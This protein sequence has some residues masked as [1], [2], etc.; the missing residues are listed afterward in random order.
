MNF[1]YQCQDD[2]TGWLPNYGSNDGALFFKLNDC[3]YRDYHPQLD[4]LHYL[5]TSEHLYDRQYEDREWYLCE[6]KAN[7][8]MYP[9]IKKQFGCISFDKGG[10]YCIREKD[11]FLL[12][13]V[14]DIRTDLRM[15]IICIWIFGI[16]EKII[17]LMGGVINTIQQRS[18]FD[19][20]WVRNLIIQ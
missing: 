1:L 18:Y 9:P 13:D 4:A 16:R 12:S 20:L 15:R 10:Y 19:I 2:L 7:R 14:E 3:D 5:L 11:T 6:W 17:C 8:Q